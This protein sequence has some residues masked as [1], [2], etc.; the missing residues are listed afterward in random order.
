MN[1]FV[2]LMIKKIYTIACLVVLLFGFIIVS[3]KDNDSRLGG[4]LVETTT[5]YGMLDTITI[6][7]SNLVAFDSVATSGT[8]IGFSGAYNDPYIGEVKAQSFIEFSRATESEAD[9]YAIFDSVCLVLRPNGNYYGDTTRYAT[10]KPENIS[11]RVYE[12]NEQIDKGDNDY[13]YSTNSMQ[14]G[15]MLAD[16]ESQIIVKNVNDNSFEVKLPDTFGE[17]LFQGILRNEDDY[18]SENFV[19]TFP[20]LA[21]GPADNNKCMYGFN[22]NDTACMIRIYYHITTTF[23]DNK[24]MTFK[25]NK[26]NS[27]YNMTNDIAKLRYIDPETNEIIPF[28]PKSNPVSSSKMGN[29]GTLLSGSTSI[30]TRLEF[31]YL[32]QLL[33]LG[34][35]V[36]IQKATLYVRPIK[37]SFDTIPLPQRI[38]ILYFDPT[39]NTPSWGSALKPPGSGSS[40]APQ[41]GNLPKDYQNIQSP[42]FPQYSFDVTDFI[43][44]QLGKAGYDKWALCLTIPRA[45]NEISTNN[46][47]S[48]STIQRLVFGDQNYCFACKGSC[49]NDYSICVDHDDCIKFE[50]ISRDNRIKLEIIYAATND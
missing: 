17:Q 41:Y 15:N 49:K 1:Y 44:Q 13:F 21:I 47:F 11:I 45:D 10:N 25:A 33:W 4:E 42:D 39:G 3:C 27:F 34:Q 36:K 19:K 8:G 18:K 23:K 9:K 26:Y 12:L 32:N 30:Y 16:D 7:V 14:V 38:T 46:P 6:K 20:G 50:N 28:D 35:I 43:S 5:M 24:Q 37:Y 31:P 29:K 2:N 22:L 40:T 48:E